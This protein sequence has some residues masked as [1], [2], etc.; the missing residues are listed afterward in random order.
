MWNA[1]PAKPAKNSFF[2]LLRLCGLCVPF[3]A[4]AH[5]Q[6]LA[7]RLAILQAEDRRA[8]TPRDLALIRSGAHSGDEQT[9][10]VAVR[11]LGRLQRPE[12][13]PEIAP[14]LRHSIPEIRSEAANAIGQA[15]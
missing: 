14:A 1:K 11:A 13:I 5:A 4:V 6:T 7:A 3:F 12:L 9:V 8:P 10:R 15:A 2:F